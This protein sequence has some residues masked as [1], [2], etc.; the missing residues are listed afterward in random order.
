MC[1]FGEV[2][3]VCVHCNHN[4]NLPHAPPGFSHPVPSLAAKPSGLS[5]STKGRGMCCLSMVKSL[6]VIVKKTLYVNDK[7]CLSEGAD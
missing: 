7:L 5:S 3:S 4:R 2:R 6:C 1:V